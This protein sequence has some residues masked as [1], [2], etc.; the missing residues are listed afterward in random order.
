MQRIIT[1]ESL[2]I[3]GLTP[4]LAMTQSLLSAVVAGLLVALVTVPGLAAIHL[5]RALVPVRQRWLAATLLVAMF[6]GIMDRLVAV[7]MPDLHQLFGLYLPVLVVVPLCLLVPAEIAYST[8]TVTPAAWQTVRLCLIYLAMMSMVGMLRELAAGGMLFQDSEM[9]TGTDFSIAL[10]GGG[11]AM[12]AETAGAL[13]LIGLL[14]AVI[15]RYRDR[16]TVHST[17]SG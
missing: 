10:A 4:L 16:Q 15:N 7:F 12:V 1:P 14:L 9:I 3:V 13:I 5:L 2:V 6:V 17:M 8:D 11:M